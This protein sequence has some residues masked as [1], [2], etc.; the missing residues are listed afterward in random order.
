MAR[1]AN[2][3]NTYIILLEKSTGTDMRITLRQTDGSDSHYAIYKDSGLLRCYAML[4]CKQ[5]QM[6]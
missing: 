2:I 4:I 3:R 6:F 1:M 5:I